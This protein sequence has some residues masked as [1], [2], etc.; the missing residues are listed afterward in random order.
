MFYITK[1]IIIAITVIITQI[2][3][4]GKVDL[5]LSILDGRSIYNSNILKISYNTTDEFK[6]I[7]GNIMLFKFLKK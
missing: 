5:I 2:I 7:N 4:P 6:I 3:L 1:D